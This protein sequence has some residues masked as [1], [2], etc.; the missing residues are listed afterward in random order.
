MQWMIRT[1]GIGLL[2]HPADI[3]GEDSVSIWKT[4]EMLALIH[5]PCSSKVTFNQGKH[6][7]PGKK[8]TTFLLVR[9]EKI[10]NYLF[11]NQCEETP[12][13]AQ[14]PKETL[15]G[16]DE[17]GNF[18]TAKAKEYPPS[19]CKAIAHG[20]LDELELTQMPNSLSE[21]E[22]LDLEA[23]SPYHVAHDPFCEE[24]EIGADYAGFK[25]H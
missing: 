20:I 18:R 3:G 23:L 2:E 24:Q 4:K 19:L 15:L 1:G 10:R 16:L 25:D 6:G 11:K 8:P 14:A 13:E 21:E 12:E 9:L 7:S 5:A 22:A 17:K